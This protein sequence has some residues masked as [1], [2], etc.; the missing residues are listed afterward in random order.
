MQIDPKYSE[1]LS[2]GVVLYNTPRDIVKELK[3][4]DEQHLEF[5]GT[6]FFDFK[7]WENYHKLELTSEKVRDFAKQNGY[8]TAIFETIWKN[9]NVYEPIYSWDEEPSYTGYP[10]MI[11]EKEDELRLTTPEEALELLNN[12]NK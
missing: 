3:E 4:I 6:N 5:Y 10:L 12:I 2:D 11:Q 1:F 9:Y 7:E 8:M